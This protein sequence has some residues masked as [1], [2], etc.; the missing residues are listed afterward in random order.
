MKSL[1][2]A[3]TALFTVQPSFAATPADP[4]ASQGN[5]EVI[6]PSACWDADPAHILVVV[7][8]APTA[9]KKTLKVVTS[10]PGA[11]ANGPGGTFQPKN[12]PLL[13]DVKDDSSG[14]FVLADGTPS[15]A[16]L[17]DPSSG[18]FVDLKDRI[19]TTGTPMAICVDAS[20]IPANSLLF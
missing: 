19:N 11:I 18:V 6:G 12:E 8:N 3:L 15:T 1:F 9:G 7:F 17:Y 14:R 13:F 16:F 5:P 4:G 10:K 20:F 2:I